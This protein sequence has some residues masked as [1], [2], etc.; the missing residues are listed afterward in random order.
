MVF[1]ACTSSCLYQSDGCCTLERAVS[2]GFP[3][4]ENSCVNYVP[5]SAPSKQEIP[6]QMGRERSH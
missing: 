3:N 6:S 4:G 5:R 1:I 2:S